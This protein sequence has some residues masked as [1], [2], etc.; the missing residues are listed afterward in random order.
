MAS[1]RIVPVVVALVIVWQYVH[2]EDPAERRRVRWV[3]YTLLGSAASYYA[4]GTLPDFFGQPAIR[5]DL[6]TVVFLAVPVAMGAAVLRYGIFDL[7]I[8]LRRS[9]VY[10]TLRPADRHPGCNRRSTR[11][12]VR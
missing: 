5:Y 10:G 11:D 6:Q 3:V 8:L 9:L 2:T 1:S 4:L 7:Q 12:Q